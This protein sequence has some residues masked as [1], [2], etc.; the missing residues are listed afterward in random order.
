M[1]IKQAY[2]AA[3]ELLVYC[4]NKSEG[5]ELI[6][7]LSC[8]DPY[9]WADG[10]AFDPATYE[11]WLNSVKVVT[12]DEQLTEMQAFQSMLEFLKFHERRFKFAPQWLINELE[13]VTY[14]KSKWLECIAYAMR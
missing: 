5:D 8:M 14:D 6:D 13:E 2:I 7:L 1:T 11:D 3:F 10:E 9:S 12:N 4:Y